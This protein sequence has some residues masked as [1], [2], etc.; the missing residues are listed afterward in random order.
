MIFKYVI[1]SDGFSS[2]KKISFETKP[3]FLENLN[4][5]Y[6]LQSFLKNFILRCHF[7]IIELLKQC[8]CYFS[9]L[10]YSMNTD[11]LK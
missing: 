10:K 3:D 7:K 2:G 5:S 1:K 8:N 4:Q 6:P 9:V 11:S